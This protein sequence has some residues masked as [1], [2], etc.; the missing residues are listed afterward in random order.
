MVGTGYNRAVSNLKYY[1]MLEGTLVTADH[2]DSLSS[3]NWILDIFLSWFPLA[4]FSM[5]PIGQVSIHYTE[6][7]VL[8]RGPSNAG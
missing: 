1:T 4:W 7:L 3:R 5:S 6:G 8:R 2:H